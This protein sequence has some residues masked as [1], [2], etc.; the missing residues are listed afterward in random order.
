MQ[1]PVLT[2]AWLTAN[3]QLLAPLVSITTQISKFCAPLIRTKVFVAFAVM[4]TAS[5]CML[6]IVRIDRP[7]FLSL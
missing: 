2:V 3:L 4:N 7:G 1:N 6:V 5:S